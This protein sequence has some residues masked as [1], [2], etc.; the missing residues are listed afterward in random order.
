MSYEPCMCGGCMTCLRAQGWHIHDRYC[1]GED[2][3]PECGQLAY[4]EEQPEEENPL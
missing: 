3:R 2:G 1:W 4:D